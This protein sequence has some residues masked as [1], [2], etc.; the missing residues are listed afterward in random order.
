MKVVKKPLL[1]L[2]VCILGAGL[3]FKLALAALISPSYIEELLEDNLNCSASVQS[4]KI[5]LW[6]R[7][8]RLQK[9]ALR[10]VGA[11]ADSEAAVEVQEVALGV[12][13]LPLLGKKLETTS[14]VIRGPIIRASWDEEG[15]LS[16]AEIFRDAENEEA[17]GGDRA[18]TSEGK[19]VLKAKE[20]RW[21]AKLS[22]PRLEDGRVELSFEK[23]KLRLEVDDVSITIGDLQFDP[24]DLATL[25][26]VTMDLAGDAQLFDSQ[27]G[28]LLKLDLAGEAKGEL[29][30]EVT[31]DFD[32]DVLADLALGDESYLNP[33]VKVVRQ[34][35]ALVGQ[36]DQIGIEVGDLPDRV[37]FGR[38][39]RI[40]CSYA[41]GTVRVVEPLSLSA[42]KWE[43]GLAGGSWVETFSGEHE[44]GVEFLAGERVSQVLGGWFEKLPKEARGL[45]QDRFVDREQVLWRVNSSGNLQDPELDFLSQLPETSG[46]VKELEEELDKS[47]DKLKEKAGNLLK[48]LFGEED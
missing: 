19:G 28:L 22:Q 48:G 18:T 43:L 32:A 35:W 3:A 23:E 27:G 41:S 11:S 30:D 42:G 26:Q 33:Q 7:E 2:L 12:R 14:F 15:D 39:R 6:Q 4:V 13:L 20:N 17:G 46:L 37:A 8:V 21:L 9:L 10:P 29:F 1:A 38:S 40:K 36:V 25:N 47:V 24:E 34:I 5:R 45:A 31:G 44:L 16:L